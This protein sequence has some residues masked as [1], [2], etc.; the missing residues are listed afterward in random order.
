[1]SYIPNIGFPCYSDDEL[2]IRHWRNIRHQIQCPK[3][4]D[5]KVARKIENFSIEGL[6]LSQLRQFYAS[7]EGPCE[8]IDY[9]L[10]AILCEKPHCF[11][12][13][14]KLFY[15][16]INNVGSWCSAGLLSTQIVYCAIR[17]PSIAMIECLVSL[18]ADLNALSYDERTLVECMISSADSF[19][20]DSD[21][22]LRCIENVK[23]WSDDSSLSSHLSLQ[24]S[25]WITAQVHEINKKILPR[26]ILCPFLG[27]QNTNP[28]ATGYI[29]RKRKELCQ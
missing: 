8:P 24:Y 12:A 28:W 5:R 29:V 27:W 20:G 10:L 23:R 21:L 25:C 14:V 22:W 17:C 16:D 26:A 3:F 4:P 11:L 9:A 2:W 13:L 18:G 7:K 15:I 19:D 6:D 1:M